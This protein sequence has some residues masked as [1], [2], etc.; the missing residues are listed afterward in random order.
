MLLVLSFEALVGACVMIWCIAMG[1]V[2]VGRIS[3]LYAWHQHLTCLLLAV[4]SYL[5]FHG[6]SCWTEAWYSGSHFCFWQGAD[7][8]GLRPKRNCQLLPMQKK[9]SHSLHDRGVPSTSSTSSIRWKYI[10][11]LCTGSR[12]WCGRRLAVSFGS[13]S[14]VISALP[15]DEVEKN[16]TKASYNDKQLKAWNRTVSQEQQCLTLRHTYTGRIRRSKSVPTTNFTNLS[17]WR[18]VRIS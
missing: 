16:H 7:H 15:D 10:S 9:P 12:S 13:Q 11:F 1:W 3:I 8:L 14:Q 17:Q 4:F 2:L 18:T 5:T 6:V